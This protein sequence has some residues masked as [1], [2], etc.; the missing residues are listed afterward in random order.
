VIRI[1][2]KDR[3]GCV[4]TRILAT[5]RDSGRRYVT[6]QRPYGVSSG[7]L[8]RRPEKREKSASHELSFAP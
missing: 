6:V 2:R 4:E 8:Q 1:E 3:S 5:Q 7:L